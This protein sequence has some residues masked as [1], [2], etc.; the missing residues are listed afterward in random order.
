MDIIYADNFD[1]HLN[2]NEDVVEAGV[3]EVFRGSEEEALA[4]LEQAVG[5]K[6]GDTNK[7]FTLNLWVKAGDSEKAIHVVSYID[8]EQRE[9][10]RD[11][12]KKKREAI[13]ELVREAID[14]G[15]PNAHAC[16]ITERILK[17]V[18]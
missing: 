15:D 18:K 3:T 2:P 10:N 5:L 12:L 1:N 16:D 7:A 14:V 13:L 17:I 8:P 9:A 6:E 11:T 4:W